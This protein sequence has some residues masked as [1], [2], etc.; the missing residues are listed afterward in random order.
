MPKFISGEVLDLTPEQIAK[1][2]WFQSNPPK[3]YAKFYK[4]YKKFVGPAIFLLLVSEIVLAIIHSASRH[5]LFDVMKYIFFVSFGLGMVSLGFYLYKHFYT[6]SYAKREFGW[7]MKMWN[8][9]TMG[10]SWD[11]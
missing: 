11:I 5:D 4:L 6:K 10:I 8:K 1:I 7:D 2:N 3:A 9:C